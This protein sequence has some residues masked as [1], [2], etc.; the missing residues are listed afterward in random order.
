MIQSII[1]KIQSVI[2]ND[3]FSMHCHGP[4]LGTL[5]QFDSWI[6]SFPPSA[7][8]MRQWI[9][10]A[11]IQIMACRLFPIILINAGLLSIGP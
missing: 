2:V 7:T 8:Y 10:S 5:D 6:N 4:A 1:V 9:G 3:F 11:L